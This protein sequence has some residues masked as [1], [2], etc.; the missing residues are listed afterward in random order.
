MAETLDARLLRFRTDPSHEDPAVLASDLL[1]GE[2]HREALEVTAASLRTQ[3]R[4]VEMLV[5][6]GRAWIGRGDLLRA[7]KT[8]LQAARLE[9]DHPDSY[10]WLGEV[11]LRRGDPA[12]ARKVLG[13]ARALGS[14]DPAVT[15]LLERAERL[16][17]IADDA[18]ADEAPT[19]ERALPPEPPTAKREAPRRKIRKP[20]A[21]ERLKEAARPSRKPVPKPRPPAPPPPDPA[22]FDDEPT[23]VAADLRKELAKMSEPPQSFDSALDG[24]PDPFADLPPAPKAPTFDTSPLSS[25]EP[26]PE[27]R[28]RK[29]AP[30]SSLFKSAP[31]PPLPDPEPEDPATELDMAAPPLP[32][33]DPSDELALPS[34]A[35]VS[36][37]P[38]PLAPDDE[39]VPFAE[40]DGP[41]EVRGDGDDAAFPAIDIPPAPAV[42]ALDPLPPP[43]MSAPAPALDADA[44]DPTSD[45]GPDF[46]PS[47]EPGEPPA[48]VDDLR[49]GAA[50]GE[51]D[52]VDEILATLQEAKLFEP[53]SGDAVGWAD[54]KSSR[55]RGTKVGL[56]MGVIGALVIGLGVGGYFGWRAWADHQ[57]EEAA[58]RVTEA[59]E[60][61]LSGDHANLVDAERLLREARELAPL[62]I[63]GPRVLIMVHAQRALEDGSFQP[64]YLRPAV[65]RAEQLEI[66]EAFVDVARSILKLAEGER[67]EAKAAYERAVEGAGEDGMDAAFANYVAGR[68]GQRLGDE[69]AEG[70]LRQALE[71]EPSFAAPAFALAEM[72]AEAGNKE[73]ARALLDAVAGHHQDHLRATLWRAYLDTD[74]GDAAAGLRALDALEERLEHGAP[75][76][77][78]LASLTRARLLRREGDNEA[79]REAVEAAASAGATEPRL[80]ALVA[81]AARALGEMTRAQQAAMSAVE[82][83]PEI[84]EYRKL[85]AK[86]L[87]ERRDGVRALRTLGRLSNDDPE[88]LELSARA[89]LIVGGA[90]ALQATMAA[91]DAQLEANEDAP[92]RLRSL[93][94][95]VALRLAE[96][97]GDRRSLLRDARQLARDAPGDADA[98]RALGE[99]A[100][101][102]GEVGDAAEALERVVAADPDDAEGHF[103]LGRAKRRQGDAEAAEEALRRAI[104]L[105]P[106]HTDARV[107]LGYLLLDRGD[108]EGADTL[109]SELADRMGT[110]G[111]GQSYQLLARLGRIDALLGL[112]R[113]ADAKVQLEGVRPEDRERAAVQLATGRVALADGQAGDAVR[114]L[115]S[116]ADAEDAG[117]DVIALYGDALRAAG[118]S[119]AASEV[120]ERALELDSEH[121]EALLGYAA[122]LLRGDKAREAR[123]ILERVEA[124][125]RRRIRPATIT[126]RMKVLQARVAL[127]RDDDD[128]AARLLREATEVEGAPADAWFF[129]GE[130]L[131]GSNSPEAR[132]AYEAYL[133][134]APRGAYASR[135]RRAIR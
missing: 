24:A 56:P 18:G 75:T 48:P 36:A 32:K 40:D 26:E 29:K 66:P 119:L 50:A 128:R 92:V 2:R 106:G 44:P 74:D 43:P 104:E 51:A 89:A 100:L 22:A 76:D 91:L 116:L 135:A 64:G 21:P 11:L 17:R 108:F 79:A 109:Y 95:L 12:R 59:R 57:D 118:E 4:D 112:G 121:P 38:P 67:D 14:S 86:I 126:A 58:T 87:V 20:H 80:Q 90:D 97:R 30:L 93:R 71:L 9:P 13:R 47:F 28:T 85:L 117:A 130:S 8:L 82:A 77:H 10:R 88:V 23:T 3:P 98:G 73:D 68:L 110:S 55:Y 96:D 123:G 125:L 5:L 63:E 69:A 37:F 124:S 1:D 33:A 133:E 102:A 54:R 42:P 52:D 72:A 94:I 107:A 120:Y 6:A 131:A 34:G 105:Q 41:T 60:D 101:A 81:K 70:R 83:A 25:P 19:E 65:D 61:A 78:V 132:A 122:I 84:P 45:F 62:D 15:Q 111:D 31:P 35:V 103:L 99:A 115:R 49:L 46:E 113:L 39:E 27:A 129:L 53:P 7:Q 127:D 134:R 114:A 16:A